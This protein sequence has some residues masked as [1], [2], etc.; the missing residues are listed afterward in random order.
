M[1]LPENLYDKPG[2]FQTLELCLID[3]WAIP[4]VEVHGK[5]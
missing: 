3:L 4:D 5:K 2:V 1:F